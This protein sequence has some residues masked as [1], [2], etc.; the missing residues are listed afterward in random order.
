[1][2]MRLAN[3]GQEEIEKQLRKHD[4]KQDYWKNRKYNEFLCYLHSIY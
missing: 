2:F 1:M 4:A 3:A